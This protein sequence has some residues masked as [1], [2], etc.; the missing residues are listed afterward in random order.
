MKRSHLYLAISLAVSGL[1]IAG[2][3]SKQ[4]EADA[5]A[6]QQQMPPAT[7]DVMPVQFQ[8]VPLIKEF[9]GRIAAYEQA[10]IRPQITGVI[11]EI[12]YREGGMVQ[13][14][15]PLYRLSDEN[16]ESS[17]AAGQAA[18]QQ[19]LANV[20]TAKA[21]YNNSVANIESRKAE[22]EQALDDVNRLRPLLSKQAI[23]EQMFRQTETRAKTAKAAYE[24]AV[25]SAQQAQA[26]IASAEAAVA[27]AKAELSGSQLNVD[28]TT[29]VAPIS[30]I[31]ERSGLTVGALVNAN[32]PDPL[33]TISKINPIYVDI[34]QSSADLLR[35]K[36]QQMQGEL[37]GG[38]SRVE[39]VLEDGTPYPEA[40][41]L[42]LAEAKVNEDSGAV[43]LR[44]IFDNERYLLLPGMYVKARLMQGMINNA[45]LL[46]QSALKRT[47]KGGTQV[48]VVDGEDKLQVREV[49]TEGTFQGNWII[50]DGLKS[51]ERVVVVGGAN[52]QPETKV[53]PRPWQPK[54]ANNGAAP[55][56]PVA[57]QQGQTGKGPVA[58]QGQSSKGPV[59]PEKN[60]EAKAPAAPATEQSS[61]QDS[62]A[63]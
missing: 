49:T 34:S 32:Q 23:S 52:L 28:R 56:G 27:T 24:S 58:P 3:N 31:T 48:Y 42:L 21:S 22:L 5:A 26:N 2:C 62:A 14:G 63:N 45:V 15:Q 59:A 8:T 61:E 39:L 17:Q 7:V 11:D 41:Q 36:Q 54:P 25:A 37:Q 38:S 33:V 50:T 30:G 10:A 6:A 16:Y 18:V 57:P 53:S 20:E 1:F 47:P 29:V 12:L 9:S 43:T 44:A 35:L 51:G 4:D 13:K 46:P 40:G 60:S 55:K 19:A